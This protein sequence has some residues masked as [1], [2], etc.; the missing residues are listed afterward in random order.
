MFSLSPQNRS[1]DLLTWALGVP[2]IR[3]MRYDDVI[4]FYGSQAAAA[5]ALSVAQPSVWGWKD[6]GIPI[7][8]QIQIELATG[9]QLK[10]D[11]PPEIRQPRKTAA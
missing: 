4:N 9:G 5:R 7:E 11:I 3:D 8:R 6:S 2:I 1:V 10:A